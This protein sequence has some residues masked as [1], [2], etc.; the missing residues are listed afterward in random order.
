MRQYTGRHPTVT[1]AERVDWRHT[2]L[3]GAATGFSAGLLGIGGGVIA[4]PLLR[5]VCRLPLRDC[6]ATSSAAICLSSLVGAI[7]KNAAI[8]GWTGATG[9][10]PGL[11]VTDSLKL[12]AIVTPMAIVGAVVGAS[13]THRLPLNAVRVAFIAIMSLAAWQMLM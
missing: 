9:L 2:S 10:A 8:A 11:D 12:A 3:V 13:L 1:P 6:I 7:Q 5:R 4:V